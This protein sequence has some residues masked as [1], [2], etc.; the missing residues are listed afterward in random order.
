[1]QP[2]VMSLPLGVA[3]LLQGSQPGQDSQL[4]LRSWAGLGP[5][6][7]IRGQRSGGGSQL[8]TVYLQ[9]T[10]RATETTL[11]TLTSIHCTD[12]ADYT[13]F[14]SVLWKCNIFLWGKRRRGW[15]K[16]IS[17]LSDKVLFLVT[18]ALNGYTSMSKFL[19]AL[20]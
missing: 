15:N 19:I 2:Y 8:L 11:I 13:D 14:V 18:L 16:V 10:E 5:V 12:N 1:M 6:W 17:E 3:V 9:P 20:L 7:E 4:Q